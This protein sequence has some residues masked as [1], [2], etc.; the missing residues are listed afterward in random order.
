MF[1]ERSPD[2]LAGGL[3]Y[4]DA[5]DLALQFQD[6]GAELLIR[7][8]FVGDVKGE[9]ARFRPFVQADAGGPEAG[10]PAVLGGLEKVRDHDVPGLSPRSRQSF[11]RKEARSRVATRELRPIFRGGGKSP[12]EMRRSKVRLEMDK[13]PAAS[14]SVSRR[15]GS[16]GGGSITGRGMA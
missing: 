7:H 2:R 15:L 6:Q 16:V 12:A 4:A 1:E 9:A 14:G 11:S 5:V 13:R 10:F 8:P 3:G